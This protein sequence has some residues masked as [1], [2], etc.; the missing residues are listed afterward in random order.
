MKRIS[1]HQIFLAVLMAIFLV[2]GCTQQMMK[3]DSVTNKGLAQREEPCW[4]LSDPECDDESGEFYYFRGQNAVPEA[5][6][7]RPSR[8]A[9]RSAE[10]AARE[11]FAAYIRAGVA[12]KMK[13]ESS[14]SGDT[15]EGMTTKTSIESA[16][17]SYVTADITGL[18]TVDIYQESISSNSKGIPLWT[19][20]ARMKVKREIADQQVAVQTK[21]VVAKLEASAE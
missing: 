9:T 12:S 5:S 7:A 4:V 8:L 2:G 18:K 17:N 3:M 6:K 16:I 13:E 14:S 21:K 19:V 11:S 20:W 15:N 1:Q 10:N